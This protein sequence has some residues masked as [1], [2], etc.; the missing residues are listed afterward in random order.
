EILEGPGLPVA[1]AL[2]VAGIG[3]DLR[4]LGPVAHGA[5]SVAALVLPPAALP[6]IEGAGLVG[7]IDAP[8]QA[9][10]VLGR[11]EEA[12]VQEIGVEAPQGIS[13]ELRRGLRA[14]ELG[15][16]DRRGFRLA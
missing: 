15:E 11:R 5:R 12:G 6:E 1:P 4:E 9:Q 3:I 16:V 2:R 13:G 14:R 7:G 10:G 8:Q